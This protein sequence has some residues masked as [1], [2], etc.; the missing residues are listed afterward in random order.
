MDLRKT[1][2]EGVDCMYL[3]QVRDDWRADV[4]T[5]MNIQVP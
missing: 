1:E 4:N 2:W 3:A 5:V